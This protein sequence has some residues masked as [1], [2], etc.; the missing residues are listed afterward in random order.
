M[1]RSR[2]SRVGLMLISLL[3]GLLVT[4]A[5]DNKFGEAFK[6]F[7]DF[8][9]GNTPDSRGPKAK[10]PWT[11]RSWQDRS[12]GGR[13]RAIADIEVAVDI[14]K[15]D[16][17]KLLGNACH[18][19][20][21]QRS[22]SVIKIRAWPGSIKT[23]AVPL[24]IAM[25]ARDGHGWDGKGVGFEKIQIFLPKKEGPPRP[26]VAEHAMAATV[27]IRMSTGET[28][29]EAMRSAAKRMSVDLEL[30]RKA[31]TRM[32]VY[33]DAMRTRIPAEELKKRS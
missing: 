7:N 14:S 22:T 28:L 26:K 12:A 2:I 24:G 32:Q 1:E 30:V 4:G 15:K 23:M 9:Q 6:S 11:T 27:E 8:S 16:L 33:Y 19:N 20:D 3:L 13:S 25:F 17:E 31:V 5:C 18:H 21:L 10:T 29:P